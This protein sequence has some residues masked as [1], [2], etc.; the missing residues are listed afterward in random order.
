M[1]IY[2][3]GPMRGY[4]EFNSPAFH[5]HAKELREAGHVVFNPAENDVE[6]GYSKRIE[7]EGVTDSLMRDCIFDDLEYIIREADA[8]ALI[9]GW[10]DSKGVAAE[11]ATANFLSLEVIELSAL[12]RV[13]L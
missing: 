11:V 2:L 4:P 12:E 6:K 7:Q 3:A 8:I 13:I 1:K 9:P 10:E 5:R